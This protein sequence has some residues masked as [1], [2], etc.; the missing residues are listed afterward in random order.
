MGRVSGSNSKGMSG[1]RENRSSIEGVYLQEVDFSP[2]P[3]GN[4]A[5]R[6]EAVDFTWPVSF[7]EVKVFAGRGSPEV[8]PWGFLLPLAPW[9]WAA[10]LSTFLLL[11]VTSSFLFTKFSEEDLGSSEIFASNMLYFVSI[12][13]RQSVWMGEGGWWWQRVVL[14]VWMLMTMVLTR[15][16]EGNLI[17]L[18]AVRH[19]PQ[20]YQTLRDVVNDPSVVMVWHKGGAPIQS[21]MVRKH[22]ELL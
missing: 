6:Y 19:L 5:A 1:I 7:V 9:V 14:G 3:F 17:S 4:N 18:L 20:P 11:S 16:Y 8:D 22:K 12:V 2:G 21:V 10:L 15:S 13:L